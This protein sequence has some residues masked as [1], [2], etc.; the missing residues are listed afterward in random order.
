M[1]ARSAVPAVDSPVITALP[2]LV[3]N[4]VLRDVC[5]AAKSVIKVDTSP[6]AVEVDVALND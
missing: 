1:H 2:A 6:R 5:G 4:E 3:E